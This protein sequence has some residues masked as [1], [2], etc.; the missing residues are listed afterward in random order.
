MGGKLPVVPFLVIRRIRLLLIIIVIL[1]AMLAVLFIQILPRVR[2]DT[3]WFVIAGYAIGVGCMFYAII[4]LSTS[5]N[6]RSGYYSGG[7]LQWFMTTS[8]IP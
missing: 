1:L 5:F 4:V 2:I 7:L 8:L 6:D 3:T